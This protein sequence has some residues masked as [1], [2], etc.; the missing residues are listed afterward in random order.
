MKAGLHL[1]DDVTLE[2]LEQLKQSNALSQAL[3]AS[4]RL[5]SLRPRSEIELRQ[6]L[7]RKGFEQDTIEQ[8]LE[9]LRG[10]G[11]V[12]D[13]AFAQYWTENRMSFNPRGRRLVL[14]ELRQKGVSTEIAQDA[15]LDIDDDESAYIAGMKKA[16]LLRM[17]S[18]DD[19]SRKLGDFLQRRGYDYGCI[20][21]AI[22]RLWETVVEE[23]QSI[24]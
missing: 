2:H 7:V 16:R 8:T 17:Q 22:R 12:D 14:A 23:D 13:V 19:F 11:L 3:A 20:R 18:Y 1:N 15:T 10:N 5:I 21:S 6:N 9:R 4:E 24:S